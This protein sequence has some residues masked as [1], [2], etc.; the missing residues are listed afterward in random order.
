MLSAKRD[1]RTQSCDRLA[2]PLMHAFRAAHQARDASVPVDLRDNGE[3]VLASRRV[4]SRNPITEAELRKLVNADLTAL[5]N[6]INLESVEDLSSAPEVRNSVLNHGFPSLAR[7][8]ADSSRVASIAQEIEEALRRFEPRLIP[9]TIKARRD[10]SAPDVEFRI[11]FRVSAELRAA[12]ANVPIE[13]LA[14]VE[15]DSGKVR[16]D[17]S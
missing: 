16:I 14:E 7:T 2:P 5:F 3:R 15:A 1:A 11:R 13:F 9:D 17:R 6:T 8:S 10:S 4:T 12:P